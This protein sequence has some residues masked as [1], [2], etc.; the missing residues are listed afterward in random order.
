MQDTVCNINIWESWCQIDVKQY[1][2]WSGLMFSV[3]M[4]CILVWFTLLF[5]VSLNSYGPV[6]TVSSLNHTF[7]TGQVWT[8]S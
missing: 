4:I 2:S 7:F 6:G 1:E 3:G 5:Y 8:S